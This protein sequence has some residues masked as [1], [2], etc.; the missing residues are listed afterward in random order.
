MHMY[1]TAAQEIAV[2]VPFV[3]L[4]Y[5]LIYNVNNAHVCNS[6]LSNCCG[7]HVPIGYSLSWFYVMYHSA[8][9]YMKSFSSWCK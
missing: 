1:V 2:D 5:D 4:F 8:D 7:V 6:G 3:F 9:W